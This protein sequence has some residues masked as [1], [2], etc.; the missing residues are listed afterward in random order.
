[1]MELKLITCELYVVCQ[2]DWQYFSQKEVAVRWQITICVA[3]IALVGLPN[4]EGCVMLNILGDCMWHQ[5]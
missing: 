2:E 1:M 4:N 5:D 3:C